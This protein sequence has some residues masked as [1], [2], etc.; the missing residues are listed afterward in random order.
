MTAQK[1]IWLEDI[2]LDQ[3]I[4]CG[5]FRLTE[6][7]IIEFA[8]AYDPQPFHLSIEA[9]NASAFGGLV[10]SSVQTIALSVRHMV[11]TLV[12]AGVQIIGGVA[13]EDVKLLRPVW[14][15]RDYAVTVRWVNK[16]P[17]ASKPDRGVA[18]IDIEVAGD[19]GPAVTYRVTYLV[20]RKAL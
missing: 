10:A 15:D 3:T 14:P 17:S 8:G 9:A 13:W 1:E 18:Q 12:A 11:T 6:R 2:V 5:S 4:P 19:D 16:R 20:K 7:E